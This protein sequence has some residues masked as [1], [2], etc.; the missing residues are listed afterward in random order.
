MSFTLRPYQG[1][2]VAQIRERFMAKVRALLYVL[3]TGGGK[4]A[5]F[6]YIAQ[7]ARARGNRVMIL[8]HRQELLTQASSSLARLGVDHGLISPRYTQAN[9]PVQIASVQTLVRRLGQQE[10]PELIIVDEA[11]HSTA[12]SYRDILRAYPKARVLGVTAT[13]VRTDGNGLG[14]EHGGIYQEMILGPTI[15]ELIADRHLVPPIVHAPELPADLEGMSIRMGDYSRK[16]QAFRMNRP[17]ITGCAIDH[18]LRLC[19]GVPAI[20]FCNG[21]EHAESVAEQF[22][23]RG[24]RARSV[25]GNMGDL[26]RRHAIEGLGNGSVDA[27]TS[28][29]L[30][31]EGV[32]VPACGAVIQLRRTMSLALWLQQ[33]GRCLRPAPGKERAY[34]LDHVGN[35]AL[36]GYPTW[37]QAWSLEGAEKDGSGGSG[38]GLGG[39]KLAQCPSKDCRHLFERGPLECPECGATLPVRGRGADQLEG[40]LEPVDQEKLRAARAAAMA[41]AQERKQKA[42]TVPAVY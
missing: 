36:H 30:I 29:D 9:H 17:T 1:R 22:R 39:V 16:D 3:P 6:S 5:V 33:I 13:P 20:V 10:A 35:V 8:V 18:Y 28:A 31:G 37:D 23:A 25:D 11:H 14:L 4:T 32:D 40:E 21:V 41:R 27:L 38:G 42:L 34:V 24:I 7:A 19:P 12:G 26:E 2:N 15:A